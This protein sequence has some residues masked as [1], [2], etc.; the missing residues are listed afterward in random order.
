MTCN[1]KKENL[2]NLKELAMST[3]SIYYKLLIIECMS[4]SWMTSVIPEEMK[5]EYLDVIA[6]IERNLTKNFG[7][8][9][10]LRKGK[11]IEQLTKDRFT[12]D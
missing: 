2:Q 1:F 6:E 3:D 11:I 12:E 4:Y 10:K 7:P 8:Q 9:G 5:N